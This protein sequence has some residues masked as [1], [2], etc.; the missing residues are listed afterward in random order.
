VGEGVNRY[1]QALDL[2]GA[3]VEGVDDARWASPSPCD[4]WSAAAVVGHVIHGSRIILAV[5]TGDAPV[6]RAGDPSAIAGAEPAR[7]WRG[8]RA[9]IERVLDSLDLDALVN[10]VQG[11]MRVDDGLGR[12]V[13]EPLV[14]AWDLATATGQEL[15]LPDRLVTPLLAALEPAD[16]FLRTSGMFADRL[17]VLPGAP[18][19][20]RLLA[21]LGRR[22]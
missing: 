6:P 14:H 19:Q 7:A 13:I 5:A 18:G 8:R 2:F 17:D 22:W 3:V 10:T 20:Q 16:G 11:V 9:E 21:L 4:G 12:A 1:R 15:S